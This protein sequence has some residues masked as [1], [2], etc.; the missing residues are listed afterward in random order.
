MFAYKIVYISGS[1]E[2]IE[3]R[4]LKKLQPPLQDPKIKNSPSP[5]RS[6]PFLPA[7]IKQVLL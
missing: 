4:D 1:K 5:K 2:N 6:Q 3:N 7:S